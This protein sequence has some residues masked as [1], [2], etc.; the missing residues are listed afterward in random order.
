VPRQIGM[1]AVDFTL[2][3]MTT[4]GLADVTLSDNFG[5]NS[6]VLLF[7]PL[8]FTGVCTQEMCGISEDLRSYAALDARIYGISVDSPFVLGEWACREKIAI[9]L[10]SDLNMVVIRAYGVLFP[11][12]AG[13]GDT[14]TRAAFVINKQGIVV[15]AEQTPTPKDLPNFEQIKAAL[16]NTPGSPRQMPKRV[17]LSG[18]SQEA[19]S[20][21]NPKLAS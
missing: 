20:K 12:L 1:P 21:P 6:T 11:N 19:A 3:T 2:K 9:P 18:I 7:F 15:Y 16:A 4:N 14:A 10:L 8:A 17:D 13:I 5:R